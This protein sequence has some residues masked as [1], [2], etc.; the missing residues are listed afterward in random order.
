MSI[1]SNYCYEKAATFVS[2]SLL[3]QHN[4]FLAHPSLLLF[5][6][7]PG[8]SN[9]MWISPYKNLCKHPLRHP[10]EDPFLLLNRTLKAYGMPFSIALGPGIWFVAKTWVLHFWSENQAMFFFFLSYSK[11]NKLSKDWHG[12]E[13]RRHILSVLVVC[14]SLGLPAAAVWWLAALQVLIFHKSPI[15]SFTGCEIFPQRMN[16][17]GSENELGWKMEGSNPRL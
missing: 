10:Q 6:A 1:S 5:C 13:E 12:R 2:W 14:S 7:A 16:S 11:G 15:I 3:L 17:K 8:N 9:H 4:Y